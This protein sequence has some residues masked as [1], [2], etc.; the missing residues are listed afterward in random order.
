MNSQNFYLAIQQNP[1][2]P[3]RIPACFGRH[4]PQASAIHR[5]LCVALCMGWIGFTASPLVAQDKTTTAAD[6]AMK[7]VWQDEFDGDSLDYCKWGVEVNAFGG[8]NSE[9]QIYTDRSENVRVEDGHL[10]IEARKDNAGISGTERE[11]SSGRVRTKH[12]GDWKYG[13]IDV[14]A[15]LPEGAGIWSAIWMLPTDDAYGGWAASG[16]IDIMEMKGQEP[17]QVLGTLHYG[18]AWPRNAYSGDKYKLQSGTFADDFHTFSVVWK[19]GQIDW[20]IDGKKYQTQTKWS[21][22]GGEFP[23]PFDQ[24][25]HLLL[26]VAVGGNFLGPPN[27]STPFPARMLVDYVRVYQ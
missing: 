10:V 8:G 4:V 1:I 6:P 2:H 26:N 20:L 15:K 18:D 7:L 19:P 11:Y 27:D 17:D 12:R 13:R 24:E 22:T 23:A 25:F 5:L 16:E 14:R 21:S 3:S 9:L